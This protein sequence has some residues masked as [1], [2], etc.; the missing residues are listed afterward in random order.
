MFVLKS[1]NTVTMIKE[2]TVDY[3]LTA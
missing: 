2:S 1:L 3:K